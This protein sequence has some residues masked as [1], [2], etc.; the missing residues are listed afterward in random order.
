MPEEY[1]E[2]APYRKGEPNPFESMM[3]RFDKACE[4]Y[5]LDEG[6]YNYLKLPIKQVIVSI[7]VRLDSGK[8][9]VFEGYRV[10]HDNIL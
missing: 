7:P 8:L 4:L 10:I 3:I 1:K 6:L 2:P 9:E 5:K